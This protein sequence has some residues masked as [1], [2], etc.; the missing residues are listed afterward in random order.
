MNIPYVERNEAVVP[1]IHGHFS[2]HVRNVRGSGMSTAMQLRLIAHAIAFPGTKFR[3][4]DHF[5][6]TGRTHGNPTSYYFFAVNLS[7]MVQ[8]LGLTG[9]HVNISD[10]TITSEPRGVQ[11]VVTRKEFVAR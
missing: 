4:S 6:S 1:D 8:N 5:T 3:I 11:E 7:R 2:D 9:V 10:L